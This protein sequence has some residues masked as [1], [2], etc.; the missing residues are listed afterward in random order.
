MRSS[1]PGALEWEI[2]I[3][4]NNSVDDTKKVVKEIQ[5]SWKIPIYIEEK[6]QGISY[7][8]NRGIRHA[9]GKL[10][11][12]TDDDVIVDPNWIKNIIT[13]FEEND[14]ECVGGKILPIWEKTKPDWLSENLFYMLALLDHGNAP[15]YL[16]QPRLWGANLA[17]RSRAFEKY[18]LFDTDRG[19][20]PN[21]LYAGEETNFLSKLIRNG[22]KVLYVPNIIVQH[23]IPKERIRK[24]YC[25]KW[26]FDQG[27]LRGLLGGERNRGLTSRVDQAGKDHALQSVL[28]YS[29]RLDKKSF[30]YELAAIALCGFILGRLR[31]LFIPR[32]RNTR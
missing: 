20:R 11:A 9:K 2:I 24:T 7:A 26:K 18:G 4:D 5:N 16:M 12:F 22:E 3:V 29:R 1:I 31:Y 13:A 6:N 19:R 32:R 8:R 23:I 10:I 15:F 28:L 17:F 30:E 21:K 14:A 27:E 25:R